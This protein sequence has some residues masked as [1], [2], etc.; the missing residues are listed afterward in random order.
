MEWFINSQIGEPC[1][2]GTL[3]MVGEA[4]LTT[5]LT[6]YLY[7]YRLIIQ[8]MRRIYTPP[9]PP[10]HA[11][12]RYLV[13]LFP[14]HSPTAPSASKPDSQ[15]R[16]L[17][18][19]PNYPSDSPLLSPPLAAVLEIMAPNRTSALPGRFA[20][21]CSSHRCGFRELI[22][23]WLGGSVAVGHGVVHCF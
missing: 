13:F 16:Q 23:G 22:D 5:Y 3:G 17:H 1:T 19:P 8:H 20:R 7:I 12:D 4:H 2:Q 9:Q 18:H 14:P 10:E 21:R 6:S 11:R 15:N